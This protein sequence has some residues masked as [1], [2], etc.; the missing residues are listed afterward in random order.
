MKKVIDFCKKKYK[1]LI[2]I[3]VVFVLLITVYFLYREY[4][5]DNYRNKQDTLVYQYFGGIKNE[6][7]AIITYN[8]NDVIVSVE[9]KD[10]KIEFD[11]T[12]IY[13]KEKNM[14]L[15]PNEM[16]IVFPLR[17]GSQYKLYKNSVYEKN[18]NIHMIKNNTDKSEYSYFFLFDGKGLFFFPDEV[19]LKIDGREYA[20][21]SSMSY[22]KIIGGYSM[23][24]YDKEKEKAEV[25]E[26][27]GKKI[28]AENDKINVGLSERYTLSFGRKILLVNP[29]NLNSEYFR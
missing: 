19:T 26:I 3:M 14:V 10:K 15:F 6:Y 18:D 27:E 29:Y 16:S 9:A 22:V 2:P 23:E 8:L 24:Y 28:T 5:Y 13:Y 1:I 4:K 21:L 7:T 17:E 12:P 20:K 11:S 25:I